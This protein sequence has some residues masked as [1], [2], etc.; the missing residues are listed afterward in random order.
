MNTA[1]IIMNALSEGPLGYVGLF[2]VVDDSLFAGMGGGEVD[3]VIED[4]L[5]MLIGNG[6]VVVGGSEVPFG[7]LYILA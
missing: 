6:V 2:K 3:D 1:T 5:D 7:R 4:A